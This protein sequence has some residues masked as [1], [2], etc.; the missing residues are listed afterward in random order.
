[1]PLLS[2]KIGGLYKFNNKFLVAELGHKNENI[3]YFQLYDK[4]DTISVKKTDYF[5][6]VGKHKNEYARKYLILFGEKIVEVT[7]EFLLEYAE[8]INE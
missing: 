7:I 5:T 3:A 6:V 2:L 4:R 8:I 1:M